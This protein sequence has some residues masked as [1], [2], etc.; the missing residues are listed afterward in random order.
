MGNSITEGKDREL[1][2]DQHGEIRRAPTS[3]A[4]DLRAE[5]FEASRLKETGQGEAM[6]QRSSIESRTD[7]RLAAT[8]EAMRADPTR[9][10]NTLAIEQ[11]T[12][13]RWADLDASDFGRIRSDSR[14]EHALEAIAGHMR[15]SAEYSDEIQKRSPSLAAAGEA[16]NA[17][18]IKVDREYGERE[19]QNTQNRIEGDMNARHNRATTDAHGMNIEPRTL[20]AVSAVELARQD[21]EDY[22]KLDRIDNV[23]GAALAMGQMAQNKFYGQEVERLSPD[24]ALRAK[25]LAEHGEASAKAIEQDPSMREA[26]AH[27]DSR[28]E[29]KARGVIVERLRTERRAIA[30]MPESALIAYS[31]SI[32]RADAEAERAQMAQAVAALAS[33]QSGTVIRDDPGLTAARQ[34]RKEQI[35]AADKSRAAVIDAAALA[36]LATVRSRET[37]K[38]VEQLAIS[39]DTPTREMR[40][41]QQLLK[42]P[43]L[44]GRVTAANDPDIAAQRVRTIKRPVSEE[45]LSQ[46][47][48]T[49]YIVSREK[50]GLF[51]Q[52]AAH[53]TFR[54]GEEQGRLA[55]VDVGKTLSTERDDKST[56]RAM[57]EV[58]A[59]KNWKEITVSGT[60]DFR[61]NAWLEASLNGIRVRGYEPREADKQLL[62][63]LQERHKPANLITVVEREHKLQEPRERS[64]AQVDLPRKHIDG[65]V[66]TAH[67]RTVLDNSRAILHSKALGE[68]FTEATLRELEAKLRGERVYVGEIVNHGKAPYKFDKDNDESYYV[69]LRTRSGDQVIWGKGLAEAMQDRQAGEQIVLQNIG[70]RDVIVNERMRDAQGHFI[71][72]RPKESQ[73]NAWKSE[74]LSKLSEKARSDFSNRVAGRQPSFGVYDAKAPRAPLQ[75]AAP[76]WR[77]PEQQRGAEQQRNERER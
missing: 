72:T 61:R 38:V 14:R 30:A 26:K 19:A 15:A 28:A 20:P 37:A 45:D 23:L 25:V 31:K 24:A 32:S 21:I 66:L 62:A 73:L 68:Q 53:F 65:D 29:F 10:S 47:L 75:P 63:D 33:Q 64:A 50:Q 74:L 42:A 70:K 52:G 16:L 34:E 17:E 57:V 43:P 54:S 59:A 39:P 27:G 4:E 2:P 46:A 67:E 48:L 12:A 36:A 11:D 8:N 55:F 69:T 76:T 35:E 18:R 6:R 7:L 49:R 40:E 56:I 71:G 60:D 13:R 41:A 9:T 3:A 22:Q 77:T 44:D 5:I 1:R 58:A 51:D